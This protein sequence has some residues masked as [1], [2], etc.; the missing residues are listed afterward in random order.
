MKYAIIIIL[1]LAL[2][3]AVPLL[4]F[5]LIEKLKKKKFKIWIKTIA[6]IGS[7][8][9][10]LIFIVC[11]YLGIFYGATPD[12]Y[13]ALDDSDKVLVS[14]ENDYYFFDNKE[15]NTN[16]IIFYSGAKV[17]EIAYGPLLRLI[18]EEGIDVYLLKMPFHFALLGMNKANVVMEDSNYSNVYLMGHSLGG[19]TA[20]SYLSS[21]SYTFKGIIFLASYPNKRINDNLSSLSIYGSN[22]Y[23]LNMDDFNKNK[24]LLP[25]NQAILK[26]DGGNHGFFGNYGDQKNDGAAAI[27]RENQQQITKDAVIKYILGEKKRSCEAQLFKS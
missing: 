22:D 27:T 24:D 20:S 23:V 10:L 19:I 7:S 3:I 4:I 9:F 13:Q 14:E 5:L 6:T 18:A 12:A 17:E 2:S 26:I 21:T 25:M 8:I 15:N 1:L 16:A 11:A